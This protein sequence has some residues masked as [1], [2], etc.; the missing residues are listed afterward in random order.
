MWKMW[1]ENLFWRLFDMI[2]FFLF[3]D[4]ISWDVFIEQET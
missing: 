3:Q 4:N 2:F 1:R